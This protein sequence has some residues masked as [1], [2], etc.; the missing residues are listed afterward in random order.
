MKRSS[1]AMTWRIGIVKFVRDC[2]VTL[3]Y[4]L[5]VLLFNRCR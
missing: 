2:G 1:R 3:F 4:I 5:P